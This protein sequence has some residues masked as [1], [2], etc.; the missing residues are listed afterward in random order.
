MFGCAFLTAFISCSKP[1][2]HRVEAN[3]PPTIN[4]ISEPIYHGEPDTSPAKY[5][6]VV[7]LFTVNKEG[8]Y[9]QCSGTLIKK[10]GSTGY[11]LTA[12]HCLEDGYI[13]VIALL[14]DDYNS[15][16]AVYV[17][18]DRFL[19]NPKYG[20]D[21]DGGLIHD[22]ALFRVQ[23]VP[24]DQAAMA[25]VTPDEDVLKAG[26]QVVFVGYGQTE[27]SSDNS[28]RNSVSGELS[29]VDELVFSYE[30]TPETGGPCFGDSGGPAVALVG[31]EQRV[32]GVTSYG[33]TLD[34]GQ[35]DDCESGIGVSARV[36][37][38][39]D[40]FIKPFLD[41]AIGTDTG[42]EACSACLS[43]ITGKCAESVS[44]CAKTSTCV[45]ARDCVESGYADG[46]V[47][48][49]GKS[50]DEQGL[51]YLD[52]V[53]RCACEQDTCLTA[54]INL[55][56]GLVPLEN[57]YAIKPLEPGE[58]PESNPNSVA[59]GITG[60][61]RQDEGCALSAGVLRD[62]GAGGV[63]GVIA[64]VLCS[65]ARRSGRAKRN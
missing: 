15:G 51:G 60:P 50:Q 38:D 3:N 6:A 10:K 13:P 25:V 21:V 4:Q 30:Q 26:D 55:C 46:D 33:Y 2:S 19:S 54:C 42:S 44:Y 59:T 43:T 1:D 14:G 40:E 8:N 23:G 18:T 31:S 22:T 27:K 56:V 53:G 16:S 17:R 63:S 62:R 47:L 65:L 29:T 48:E 64:T 58:Q 24:S 7:A 11:V 61:P 12:A 52:A 36:S 34:P 37:A 41:N 28:V 32:V 39:Y 49:C 9:F 35:I 45:A 57:Y 5:P 20:T